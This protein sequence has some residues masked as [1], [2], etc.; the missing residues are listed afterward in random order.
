PAR[1]YG[2]RCPACRFS[3]GAERGKVARYAG[4]VRT[5]ETCER[6]DGRAWVFV[7]HPAAVPAPRVY[8]YPF[9]VMSTPRGADRWHDGDP[10]PRHVWQANDRETFQIFDTGETWRPIVWRLNHARGF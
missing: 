5:L 4:G 8:V 9:D 6:C 1:P 10:L 7:A 3:K 2:Y